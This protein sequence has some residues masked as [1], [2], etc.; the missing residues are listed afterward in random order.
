MA[1]SKA[2]A[3]AFEAKAKAEAEAMNAKILEQRNGIDK[4]KLELEDK[5][6]E[7]DKL[8]LDLETVSAS[9]MQEA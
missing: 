6:S 9:G 4:L 1:F 3:E 5:C 8:K 7:I 2:T